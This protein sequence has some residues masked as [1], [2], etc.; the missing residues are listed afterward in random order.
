VIARVERVA[1]AARVRLRGRVA[2]VLGDVPGISAEETDEGV[3]V[4]GRRLRA[5]WINDAR[6]R[7]LGDG[8]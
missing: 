3:V 4:S 7:W 8:L 6:L 2:A 1:K 5:R